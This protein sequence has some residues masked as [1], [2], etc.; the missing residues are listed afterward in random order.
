[1]KVKN[2]KEYGFYQDKNDK[3]RIIETF[4]DI[5]ENDKEVMSVMIWNYFETKNG[6]KF[7]ETDM[8]AFNPENDGLCDIEVIK[9]D[10]NYKIVDDNDPYY[11]Q[12]G[13]SSVMYEDKEDIN[14]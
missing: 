12:Y 11:Y 4:S 9:L 6:I 8:F 1:M 5:D 3:D 14:G 7:Y 2:I 10:L 13:A